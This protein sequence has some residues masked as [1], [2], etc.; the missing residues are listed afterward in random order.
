LSL[1]Y[2][3]YAIKRFS[4]LRIEEQRTVSRKVPVAGFAA[5]HRRLA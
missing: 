5:I 2:H 3:G 1:I 4:I